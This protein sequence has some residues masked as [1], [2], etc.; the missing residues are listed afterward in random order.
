MLQQI[1]RVLLFLVTLSLFAPASGVA[2]TYTKIFEPYEITNP[3]GSKTRVD[4]FSHSG[5]INGN[6][7]L[8]GGTLTINGD[9]QGNLIH[10]NGYLKVSGAGLNITGDYSIQTSYGGL[11]MSFETDKITVGGN[12]SVEG[13]D[14][15]LSAGELT[16]L[17]DF[18]QTSAGIVASES[19][20]DAY[21]EHKVILAGNGEQVVSFSD[22]GK[23]GPGASNKQSGFSKLHISN[24]SG[25]VNFATAVRIRN[26]LTY[27]GDVLTLD[28]MSLVDSLLSL[29]NDI[30]IQ[31]TGSDSA[32]FTNTNLSLNGHTLTVDGNFYWGGQY[33]LDISGGKL[34]ISGGLIQSGGVMQ[35]GGGDLT[36]SGNYRIQYPAIEQYP[37]D[38]DEAEFSSSSGRLNMFDAEDRVTIGGDFIMKQQSYS[39]NYLTNGVMTLMGDFSQLSDGDN[40]EP[41]EAHKVMLAGSSEQKIYFAA[42]DQSDFETLVITN[43]SN[44][45]VNFTSAA[46]VK[47]LFEH[48]R[49]VFTLY[50]DSEA[51]FVD[52]DEDGVKDHLDAYPQNASLSSPDSDG[53]GIQDTD[54]NCKLIFNKNQ[55]DLDNDGIGN[56]CDADKDGDRFNNEIDAFPN[57]LSEWLDSDADQVGNNADT[58]DDNDGMSDAWELANGLDSLNASDATMDAD[59]DNVSNLDEYR[60]STDPQ[61][62]DTDDDGINDDLDRVVGNGLWGYACNVVNDPNSTTRRWGINQY[63]LADQPNAPA[64]AVYSMGQNRKIQSVACDPSG[65]N[66]LFSMKDSLRGDYEI[67]ELDTSSDAVTQITDNTTD[68]VDVTRSRDRRTIAWQ[69]RLPDNRQAIELRRMQENGEYTVKTMA[70]ATPFVQPALS[71]NGLWMSFVQLRPNFFAVMRYDITNNKYKEVQSIARRKKLYHPSI[72]DNGNQVGW[73]E[74]VSQR[75]YRVKDMTE[76]TTVDILNDASGIEHAVLSGDGEHVIYTVNASN[77][78][79]TYLTSL[80]TLDTQVIGETQNDPVRYLSANWSGVTASQVFSDSQIS[81]KLLTSY[82]QSLAFSFQSNGSGSRYTLGEDDATDF[83]WEVNN[84]ALTMTDVATQQVRVMRLLATTDNGDQLTVSSVSPDE[85]GGVKRMT[86]TIYSD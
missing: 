64:E 55:A 75:R 44:A 13:S 37:P 31:L 48:N 47:R 74:R 70:S 53:D 6:V 50:S 5:T 22:P 34:I 39:K 56:V 77:I 18:T 82:N 81:G 43:S 23:G 9:I 27:T 83:N 80:S 42:P 21:D 28:S 32:N 54:D 41:I 85:S 84:S 11:I 71:A 45:G 33:S 76:G 79:E 17:G 16:V 72:T 12:F 7:L 24:T 60:S 51:N 57:N 46:K 35:V 8:N 78:R 30:T 86:D 59:D 67:F 73:S 61:L 4:T 20:F 58:D 40:F 69:K 52:F 25:Q 68:D 2:Q 15:T 66:I 26:E 63:N 65:E 3:D 19:T 29:T 36:V 14:S 49:K 10:A 62:T 1:T 38:E